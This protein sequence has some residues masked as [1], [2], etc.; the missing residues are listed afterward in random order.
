MME[1]KSTTCPMCRNGCQVG[2]QFDGYQYRVEYLSDVPPNNGRLCPRGNGNNIVIDHPKRLSYPLLNGKEINWATAFDL[3]KRW[4]TQVKADEIAVVYSR[5][6]GASELGWVR[7]LADTLGTDNLVCGYLEPDNAFG[8][9]LEGVRWATL[10]DLSATRA[11]LLVGD[12]FS[13]SPVAAK[14]I[15]EARYADKKSRL[16]VIDSI[17]TR[18]AGFA[19]LFL[20]PR[21]GTEYLVMAGIAGLLDPGLKLDID[22]IV[23]ATGVAKEQMTAVAD[24]LKGTDNGLVAVAACLGRVAEPLWHSLAAQLVALKSGKPFVG[25]GEALVPEGKI[26]FGRLKEKIVSG[27]IKLVFWFGGLYPYSYQELLPELQKIEFRIATS[28]FRPAEPLPGL[29]LPVPSEL[30]K[31]GALVTLWGRM[32]CHSVAKPV[33]GSKPVKEIVA[34]LGVTKEVT[35][36]AGG[37]VMGLA[38]VIKGIGL[39]LEKQG[40]TAGASARSSEDKSRMVLVGRKEAI[41]VA[42]FFDPEGEVVVHPVDARKLQ[43]KDGDLLGLRTKTGEGRFKV[44]VMLITAE[45]V[46]SIG[47]N[48]HNNRRLFPVEFDPEFGNAKIP[49]T[50]VE[51]WQAQ[52]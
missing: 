31:E 48:V 9:Q 16:A 6:A 43:V 30:E 13:T 51:V 4:C 8:Y 1:I 7:A 2:I 18:Q 52:A 37:K 33:S 32:E 38:D 22:G 10:D 25:F 49:P 34:Q 28:I 11:T 5:G 39:A 46:L 23:R 42:G 15:I 47:V 50:E 12:V 26:G 14:R 21:P 44:R 29:V 3:M 35:F 40:G 17:K 27:R 24:L 45:G 41:G 19:H 36:P 20:Q